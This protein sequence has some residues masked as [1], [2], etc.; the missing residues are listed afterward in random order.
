MENRNSLEGGKK[1]EDAATKESKKNKTKRP[2]PLPI[3][4]N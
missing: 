1:D 2:Q 4:Y 3:G